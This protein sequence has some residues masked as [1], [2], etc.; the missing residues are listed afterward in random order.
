MACTSTLHAR[1]RGQCKSDSRREFLGSPCR[2]G[3]ELRWTK[4][5]G[6]P[7]AFL[8]RCP[9]LARCPCTVDTAHA[10]VCRLVL[11]SG[12]PQAVHYDTQE[13]ATLFLDLPRQRAPEPATTVSQ[14]RLSALGAWQ[15]ESERTSLCHPL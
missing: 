8:M 12:L 2:T 15:F 7:Q 6:Q 13:L 10:A 14:S 9:K 11:F 4:W 3:L 5:Y 1:N